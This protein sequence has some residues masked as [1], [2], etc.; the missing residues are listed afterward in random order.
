[1]IRFRVKSGNRLILILSVFLVMGS[2]QA[3]ALWKRPV[4]QPGTPDA[5]KMLKSIQQK[6]DML[7]QFKGISRFTQE[8]ADIRLSGRAAFGVAPPD[9][10]RVDILSPF[11]QPLVRLAYNG[12][13]IFMYSGADDKFRSGVATRSKMKNAFGVPMSIQELGQILGGCT[14]VT[15][16]SWVSIE[17][18]NYT[19]ASPSK[20]YLL[21][22]RSLIGRTRE[23]IYV[24]QD[25]VTILQADIYSGGKVLYSVFP[26]QEN[27][28]N[29]RILGKDGASIILERQRFWEKSTVDESQFMLI[30]DMVVKP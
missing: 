25:R 3:C 26:P 29:I 28:G 21:T 23:K 18:W 24:A 14:P 27:G 13:H 7:G 8:N 15:G 11:G 6:F 20:G 16:Y 17:P 4:P 2:L 5:R 10:L 19:D 30:K 12:Q 9:R 1:M 22:L